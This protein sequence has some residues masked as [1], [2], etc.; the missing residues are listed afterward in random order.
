LPD[1]ARICTPSLRP[2]PAASTAC[3]GAAISGAHAARTASTAAWHASSLS[4]PFE[5]TTT[6][7]P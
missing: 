7:K 3:D 6:P 5:H 4:P 1:S 2:G